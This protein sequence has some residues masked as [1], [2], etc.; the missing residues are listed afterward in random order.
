MSD[1][2]EVLVECKK[3]IV[4]KRGDK[5]VTLFKSKTSYQARV[6]GKFAVVKDETGCVR[7]LYNEK[8][9]KFYKENFKPIQM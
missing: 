7:P 6:F 1:Y 2:N 5:D 4:V 3:D 8:D 9:D